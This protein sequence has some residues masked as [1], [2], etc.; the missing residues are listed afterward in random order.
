MQKMTR[1]I[2]QFIMHYLDQVDSLLNLVNV[3]R[4]ENWECYLA[5]LE[6]IIKC[7]FAHDLLIYA[8]LMPVHL[9]QMI[10]LEHDDPTTWEALKEG[11][12][13]VAKS[14]ILSLGC[15]LT[16]HLNRRSRG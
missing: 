6:N 9:A 15:S 3:C 16:R 4:S 8:R 13:V 14:E 11:D 1:E 12:F 5:A 2:D 7:F 10:A